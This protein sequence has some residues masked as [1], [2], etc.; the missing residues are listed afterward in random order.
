MLF[1]FSSLL[2]DFGRICQSLLPSNPELTDFSGLTLSEKLISNV[3]FECFHLLEA[4]IYKAI[5]RQILA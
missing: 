2:I 3:F 1:L 5:Q 4:F